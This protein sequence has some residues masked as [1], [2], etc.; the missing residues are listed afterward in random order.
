MELIER[1]NCSL[2]HD[3]QLNA[4]VFRF[5]FLSVPFS[6]FCLVCRSNAISKKN[7]EWLQQVRNFVKFH[8][9]F[10]CGCLLSASPWVATSLKTFYQHIGMYVCLCKVYLQSS[11]I[12]RYNLFVFY[13]LIGDVLIDY[14]SLYCQLHFIRYFVAIFISYMDLIYSVFLHVQHAY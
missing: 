3:T 10:F 6:F 12:D 1:S 7:A 8:S 13:C 14:I 5:S 9:I 11:N 2:F 4:R